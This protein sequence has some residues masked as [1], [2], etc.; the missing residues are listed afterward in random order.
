M[1]AS[2][3]EVFKIVSEL[4]AWPRYL[5]HYRWIRAM[6]SHHDYQ[7]VR[8]ACYRGW[9]PID[10]VSRFEVDPVN[11][12]LRFTHQKAFTR[13]MVVA[14]T[15]EP[16]NGKTRVTI[17]HDLDPVIQRWG[18]LVAEKIIGGFFIHYV[19]TRTLRCFAQYFASKSVDSSTPTVVKNL[20]PT[21]KSR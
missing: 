15:L 21:N 10:W 19:A 1:M 9:I 20:C 4:V 16:I 11:R 6:E 17:T 12:R 5:P 3:E 8:M 2:P 18:R 13:G 14:W 7:I